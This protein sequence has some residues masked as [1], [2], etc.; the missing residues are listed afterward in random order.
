MCRTIKFHVIEDPVLATVFRSVQ[1]VV[2]MYA[3]WFT[4]WEKG[5]SAVHS[6]TRRM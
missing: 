1:A 5:V 4:L 2:L 6:P 3:I